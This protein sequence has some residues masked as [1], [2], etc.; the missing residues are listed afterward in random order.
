VIGFEMVKYV[1]VLKQNVQFLKKRES[2]RNIFH[3]KSIRFISP[4][5][6]TTPSHACAI[7]DRIGNASS[8]AMSRQCP[9]NE[10]NIPFTRRQPQ[11][12]KSSK[13]MKF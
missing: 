7:C 8:C 13:V 9:P 12:T 11:L 10:V 6:P 2:D 5:V 1:F 3:F 4:S